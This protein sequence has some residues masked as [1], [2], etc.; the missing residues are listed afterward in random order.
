MVRLAE[1]QGILKGDLNLLQEEALQWIMMNEMENIAILEKERMK[2][3]ILAGNTHLW[4]ELYGEEQEDDGEVEWIVP[5]S[6]EEFAQIENILAGLEEQNQ[7]GE[8]FND[9]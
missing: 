1:R 6:A 5:K 9:T 7:G 8:E 3:T 2:Y 4:Q